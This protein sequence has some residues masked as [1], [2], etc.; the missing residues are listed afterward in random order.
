M[1]MEGENYDY[2]AYDCNR[3]YYSS[4]IFS[5]NHYNDIQYHRPI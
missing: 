4:F 1:V 3:S 5:N 2:T